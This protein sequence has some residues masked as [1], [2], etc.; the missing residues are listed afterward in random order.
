MSTNIFE[1]YSC[2]AHKDIETHMK[3]YSHMTYTKIFSVY[4]K[5]FTYTKI[6]KRG[7]YSN[8]EVD[9]QLR[10]MERMIAEKR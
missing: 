1:G 9:G 4:E 10:E 3:R 5:I 6:L 2:A 8:E 7:I